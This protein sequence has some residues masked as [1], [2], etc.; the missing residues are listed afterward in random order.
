MET[1]MFFYLI[2]NIIGKQPATI[3]PCVSIKARQKHTHRSK[4]I[5]GFI[6]LTH[7]FSDRS[8]G[9]TVVVVVMVVVFVCVCVCGGATFFLK[10]VSSRVLDRDVNIRCASARVSRRICLSP[11]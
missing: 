1:E 2:L 5:D 10:N 6:L 4:K 3:L 11:P 7:T 8:A 9:G